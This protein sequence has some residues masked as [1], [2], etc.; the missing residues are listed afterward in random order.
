MSADELWCFISA[1]S[2]GNDLRPYY[3]TQV[4]LKNK[5]ITIQCDRYQFL[6]WKPQLQSSINRFRHS[7]ALQY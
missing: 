5:Q 7:D 4:H 2:F 6:D 1:Y 3:M